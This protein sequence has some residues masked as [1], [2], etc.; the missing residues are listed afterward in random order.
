MQS[1]ESSLKDFQ[2]FS[3][4]WS[5]T[6]IF[7]IVESNKSRYT[8]GGESL[9]YLQDI[10]PYPRVYLEPPSSDEGSNEET[11][12][13]SA[14]SVSTQILDST[15]VETSPTP[16]SYSFH[17]P[18]IILSSKKD[19]QL[20]RLCRAQSLRSLKF[21]RVHYVEF[22][23]LFS[24]VFWFKS[25]KTAE[26]AQKLLSQYISNG[27]LASALSVE[28]KLTKDLDIKWFLYKA[29]DPS[30]EWKGIILRNLSPKLTALQVKKVLLSQK[31]IR[32]LSE[33]VVEEPK[34]IN[35]IS[36]TVLR[37]YGDV[38]TVC[39]KIQTNHK[40]KEELGIRC[41]ANLHPLSHIRRSREDYLES[42]PRKVIKAN[43]QPQSL[44][45]IMK[46]ASESNKQKLEINQFAS[47]LKNT[48]SNPFAELV[49]HR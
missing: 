20:Q 49:R 7:S 37:I 9:K 21:F 45:E 29:K 39:N 1:L 19:I 44:Q 38:E 48:K 11:C 41:K 34:F 2:E 40:I 23:S 46:I 17:E 26:K 32:E 16:F 31:L 10:G 4:N 12:V 24:V 33:A 35:N 22:S 36:C 15:L 27:D 14:Y 13:P 30:S 5:L 3:Q 43:P 6:D 18:A 47:L 8:L 25:I 42:R 28:R